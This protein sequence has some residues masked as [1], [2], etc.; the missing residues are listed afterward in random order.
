MTSRSSLSEASLV[1]FPDKPFAYGAGPSTLRVLVRAPSDVVR[2]GRVAFNDRYAWAGTDYQPLKETAPLWRYAHDGTADY[3]AA[4]LALHPPR[5]RYRFGLE[6]QADGL[7]WFG[8][9]GL[10][11]E[12]R[13]RGAFEFAY[14]AEGDRTVSPDWARGAVFYH[15]FP[16]R[17]ASGSGAPARRGRAN[18]DDVPTSESFFGGDLDG[19]TEHLDHIA[20]L[21]VDALYLTP[22]FSAP[23]N[24]KD[25]PADYVAVDPAVGG[26]E[27][28]RRLIG[29]VH[30]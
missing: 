29:A 27:A 30:E 15:I 9:D 11:D 10:R 16:D 22:I 24:H 3:W 21:G 13:P 18:W 8:A 7:R 14:L 6:T 2:G 20:S 17:F 25:A 19:I 12:P 26:D 23:S 28:L 1:H 4:D 5:I